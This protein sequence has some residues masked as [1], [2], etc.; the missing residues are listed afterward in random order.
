MHVKYLYSVNE[1]ATTGQALDGLELLVTVPGGNPAN[2]NA[3][4]EP[5]AFPAEN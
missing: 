4:L 2:Q 5:P 3:Y 1:M